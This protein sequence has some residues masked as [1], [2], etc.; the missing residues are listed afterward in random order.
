MKKNNGWT[1]IESIDNLPK[2]ESNFFKVIDKENGKEY[3]Y[4]FTFDMADYWF[5]N[6]S[7]YRKIEKY[8][9]PIF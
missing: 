5:K 8:K 6:F 3:S 2:E 1:K 7:H 9:M 4:H